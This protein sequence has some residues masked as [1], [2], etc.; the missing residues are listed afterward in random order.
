MNENEEKVVLP[1]RPEI[2][3]TIEKKT[4]QNFFD[5]LAEKIAEK[6]CEKIVVI[7]L[8][9]YGPNATGSVEDAPKDDPN[10]PWGD[11]PETE[12]GEE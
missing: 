11:E 2:T 12:G 3:F 4:L 9:E 7:R 5:G 8:N 6:I 10:E 1:F